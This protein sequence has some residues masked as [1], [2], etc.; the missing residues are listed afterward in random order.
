MT[1]KTRNKDKQGPLKNRTN[2]TE[3]NLSIPLILSPE[4]RLAYN[5]KRNS[6]LFYPKKSLAFEK[7]HFRLYLST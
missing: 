3:L 1:A 4:F 7:K 2:K 6:E 5:R